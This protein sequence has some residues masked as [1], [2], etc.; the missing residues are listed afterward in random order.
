MPQRRALAVLAISQIVTWGALYYGY[1]MTAP[2]MIAE[3]GWSNTFVY[4]GFSVMLLASGMAA[5]FVGRIIDAEGGKRVMTAGALVAALGMVLFA[6]LQ[7]APML[8][9]AAAVTGMGMAATL[10]ESAFATLTWL[11]HSR[12]RRM[13]T[14]VTLTGGLASTVFWPLTA[15]LLK[16]LTW[17]EVCWVYAALHV[18]LIAPLHYWGLSGPRTPDAVA[19][20]AHAPGAE[21]STETKTTAPLQGRARWTAFILF[22][23]VLITHGFVTNGVSLHLLPTLG[24]LG[25]ESG[26]ALLI[27]SLIGPAQT[28][29]RLLELLFGKYVSPLALGLFAVAMM[30]ASF[31]L[32]LLAPFGLATMIAFAL[33]YGAGNGLITIARGI[34]PLSLFGREGFGAML[35]LLAAPALVSKAAGPSILAWISDGFGPRAMLLVCALCALLAFTAMVALSLWRSGQMRRA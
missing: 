25:M 28:A 34:I 33:M 2:L 29:A 21:T 16:S 10:Y 9:V 15:W 14:L 30:P 32:F 31:F 11:D 1:A 4:A 8:M 12:A 19:M 22:A 23:A 3:F 5:P 26:A 27:G 18:F 35:G 20:P 7:S 6:T 13:I 24:A 17:R